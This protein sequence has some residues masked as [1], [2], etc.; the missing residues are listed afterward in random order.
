MVFTPQRQKEIKRKLK[1]EE[2]DDADDAEDTE[3]EEETEVEDGDAGNDA[4]QDNAENVPVRPDFNW[5]LWP[6]SCSKTIIPYKMRP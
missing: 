2:V 3:Q 1:F 5:L 4:Q 6:R